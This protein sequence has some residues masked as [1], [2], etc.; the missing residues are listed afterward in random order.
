MAELNI[1]PR[2]TN[3][4]KNSSN[5]KQNP[6]PISPLLHNTTHNTSGQIYDVKPVEGGGVGVVAAAVLNDKINAKAAEGVVGGVAAVAASDSSFGA[7]II[8]LIICIVLIFILIKIYHY[9]FPNG[10]FPSID[11][12]KSVAKFNQK[13]STIPDADLDALAK[14]DTSQPQPP[15]QPQPQSQQQH[16]QQHQHQQQYQ[17]QQHSQPP[18]QT[19]QSNKSYEVLH[20]ENSTDEDIRNVIESNTKISQSTDQPSTTQPPSA[21]QQSTTQQPTTQLSTSQQQSTT[22]LST[23]QQPQVKKKLTIKKGDLVLFDRNDDD[24]KNPISVYPGIKEFIAEN[25]EA[26][27]SK[28]SEAIRNGTFYMGNKFLIHE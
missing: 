10:L 7:N 15:P 28:V 16:Q 2:N 6:Q 8:T 3:T 14:L 24:F 22:Q 9:W 27:E 26:E 17:R 4:Y 23:A 18:Q 11:K 19:F 12:E 20:S 1:N 25:P 5:V 13:V 21:S